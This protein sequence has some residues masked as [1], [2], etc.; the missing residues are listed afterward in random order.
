MKADTGFPPALGTRHLRLLLVS[1]LLHEYKSMGCQFGPPGVQSP[2]MAN[3]TTGKPSV[4]S[5]PMSRTVEHYCD[6]QYR[7]CNSACWDTATGCQT[8]QIAS[9]DAEWVSASEHVLAVTNQPERVKV[10]SA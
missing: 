3:N 6:G 7:L 4:R 1:V 2:F 5:D 10:Q 9:K 8:F